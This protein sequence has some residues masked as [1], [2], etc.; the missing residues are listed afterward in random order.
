PVQMHESVLADMPCFRTSNSF[1]L[2]SIDL[3][4]DKDEIL[5]SFRKSERNA[6]SRAER[7]QL[8]YRSG[9]SPTLLA[10][11]YKLYVGTRRRHGIPP[12]PY[13]WFTNL[14]RCMNDKVTIRVAAKNEE[15][16]AAIVTLSFPRRVVY[17]YGCSD[18][19]FNNLGA[20]PFL[21]WKTI[22]EA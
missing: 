3:R 14:V 4:R 21:C 18:R 6:I 22:E 9:T 16:I 5:R 15:P 7:E 19:K 10:Q 12:Q 11:F 17:K 2:H 13:R 20:I 8:T 1:Y